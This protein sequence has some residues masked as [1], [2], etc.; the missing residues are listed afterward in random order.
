MQETAASWRWVK[1]Y[2]THGKG[3]SGA[4][5]YYRDFSHDPSYLKRLCPQAE[6]RFLLQIVTPNGRSVEGESFNGLPIFDRYNF[7][8][9][10]AGSLMREITRLDKIWSSRQNGGR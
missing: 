4:Q 8:F 9:P 5:Y 3:P 2:W 6:I 1:E 7:G 10:C